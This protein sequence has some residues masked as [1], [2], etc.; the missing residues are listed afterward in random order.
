M[1]YTGKL[2]KPITR[3][4]F[5][6]L[7]SEDDFKA[8]E[9]RT[10]SEMF[11]KLPDLFKAHGVTEHD[12]LGL[13]LAMAKA[14]VPGFKLVKPAGRK[15][16]WGDF[17]KAEFRIAVDGTREANPGMPVTQAISRVCRLP[18]WHEKTEGMKVSALSKHYYGADSRFIAMMKDAK[19]YKS[20]V[21]ED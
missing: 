11:T 8:E 20:I 10:K 14:H 5:G 15:T 3:K 1:K 9:H 12:Y 7:A 18:S 17:D 2:S 16:E 13:I 4:R 19:A 21:R 6:L